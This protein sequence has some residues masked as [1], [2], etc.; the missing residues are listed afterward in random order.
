MPNSEVTLEI[1]YSGSIIFMLI[2]SLTAGALSSAVSFILTQIVRDKE[3]KMRET[4]KIMSLSKSA[5]A[6][7]YYLT[8]GLFALFTSLILACFFYAP[9]IF[10]N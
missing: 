3:T 2:T 10:M 9:V 5:Y 4:L 7:S 6:L 1:V 8:Q